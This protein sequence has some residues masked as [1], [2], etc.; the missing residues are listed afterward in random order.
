[1]SCKYYNQSGIVSTVCLV[2]TTA[3]MQRKVKRSQEEEKRAK[4][5]KGKEIHTLKTLAASGSFSKSIS[6]GS[7]STSIKSC[8]K[9]KSMSLSF[10]KD[11]SGGAPLGN[12]KTFNIA[13]AAY[14]E[15]QLHRQTSSG[16]QTPLRRTGH[17]N[18]G[19]LTHS[20]YNIFFI[21]YCFLT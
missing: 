13:T 6:K 3:Y 20:E 14:Q 16:C 4:A 12:E 19:S 18:S 7:I 9:S 10:S 11:D 1:M 5:R 21:S 17:P 8:S 15:K 2:G